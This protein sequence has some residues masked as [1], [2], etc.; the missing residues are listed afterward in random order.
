MA[1]FG[2]WSDK[3]RGFWP[4]ILREGWDSDF[5]WWLG[6]WAGFCAG[7]TSRALANIREPVEVVERITVV[8]R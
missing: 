5:G 6:F 8:G 4:R 1:G 3:I 2:A 7:K